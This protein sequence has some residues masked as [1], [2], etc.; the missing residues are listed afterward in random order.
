MLG[1]FFGLICLALLGFAV[2]IIGLFL[3]RKILVQKF[4]FGKYETQ[5]SAFLS[6]AGTLYSIVLGLVVANSLSSFDEQRRNVQNESTSLRNIYHLS[7]GLP[8]EFSNKIDR[9]II[10]YTQLV[11]TKEWPLMDSGNYSP[12]ARDKFLDIWKIIVDFN[13]QNSGQS[14]IHDKLIDMITDVSNCR[15][16][17]LLASQMAFAPAIHMFLWIG[18]LISIIFTYFFFIKNFRIQVLMTV[19][20]TT[21]ILF[22]LL[23]VEIFGYPFSGD[24]KIEPT[25]FALDL[26]HYKMLN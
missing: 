1:T 23:I 13:P 6:I 8:K 14:N 5:A 2:V 10:D 21:L 4:Y 3:S 7:L 16:Q 22:N 12:Q 26:K 11:I 19:L 9:A 17:R 18:G 15:H 24:I 25:S 20:I